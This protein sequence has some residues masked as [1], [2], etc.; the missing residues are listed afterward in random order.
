MLNCGPVRRAVGG[1][2]VLV[3]ALAVGQPAVQAAP[4]STA[5]ITSLISLG[6][7]DKP[8]AGQSYAPSISTDGRYVAFDS[9]ADNLVPGDTNSQNDVFVRDRRTGRTERVS[10]NSTG[11]QG[12]KGSFTPAI[13]GDGRWVAFVSDADNLV[14]GD[15]NRASDVFLRDRR[16][17]KTVRLSVALDGRETLGGSSP[18]ISANGRWVVYNVAS[19]LISKGTDEDLAGMFVHDTRTGHSERL[20]H[21]EGDDPTISADGR[22]VAFSSEIRD[23]VPGDTN[24]KADC[25]VFDRRTRTIS[26]VSLGGSKPLGNGWFRGNKQG[27]QEST[28]AVISADGHYVAFVS[29]AR[30]LVPKDANAHDDVF[31]RDLRTGATRLVSIGLHGQGANGVSG[32]PSLSAD[33]QTVVFLSQASNLIPHDRNDFDY[34]VFRMDLRTGAITRV[35]VAPTGARANGPTS[36]FP[37]ISGDGRVVTFGSR[38]SNLVRGDTND[39]DDVF[40]RGDYPKRALRS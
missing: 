26:R 19:P 34:D 23:L 28:G 9:D 35:N 18:S 17:N 29:T 38:A 33:G 15:T 37:M 14:P 11:Q 10:L 3:L 12:D 2:A 8:S 27:S 7:H 21:I 1:S 24:R 20:G 13:S 5:P 32:G 40:V 6:V 31:V 16:R 22:Y 39:H 36:S 25:F 4:L 30:N